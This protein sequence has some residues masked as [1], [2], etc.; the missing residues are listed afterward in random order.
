VLI[1]GAPG[2]GK[3]TLGTELSRVLQIPFLAR[4][5]VRRGLFFTNGAWTDH[6]GHVPTSEETVDTFLHVLEAT[7]SLG[8]SCIVEYVVRR[9]RPADLR[10]ITAAGDCVVVLAECRD[11][12]GRFA[13]RHSGDQLLNRQ[14]VLEAL[15]YTAIE[16][17]TRDTLAR[18][19]SVP[20][21]MRTRFDLPVLPVNTDEGYDPTLEAIV[22]FVTAG[23][24]APPV[25]ALDMPIS[26]T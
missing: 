17:H 20:R 6:P 11:S 7:T 16:D 2:S 15:G 22:A 13:R 1:T 24:P 9:D 8:V 10:R 4:D 25:P 23:T 18:M 26:H 21:E 3:T 12:L 14:P 5:D 19:R